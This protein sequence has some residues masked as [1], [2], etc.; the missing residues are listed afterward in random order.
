MACPY[1]SQGHPF[2]SETHLTSPSHTLT[3]VFIRIWRDMIGFLRRLAARPLALF[4]TLMVVLAVAAG[5]LYL[6]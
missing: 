3:A 4:G 1:P 5:Y 6:F 2:M